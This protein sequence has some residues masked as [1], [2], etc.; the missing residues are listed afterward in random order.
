M[1][2]LYRFTEPIVLLVLAR[3]G[4][5]H[6]YQIAAEAAPMTVTHAGLDGAAIYRALRRLEATACVTSG[7]DTSGGGPA[8]RLYTLTDRGLEHLGEWVEVMEGIASAVNVLIRESRKVSK[9]AKPTRRA[10]RPA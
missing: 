4:T 10:A 9:T 3:L 7:W 1:G 2:N 6:G 8:R 5:A